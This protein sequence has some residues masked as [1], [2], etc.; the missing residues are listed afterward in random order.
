MQEQKLLELEKE[1]AEKKRR[2]EMYAAEREK[3]KYARAAAKQ[4][5]LL[6]DS[7]RQAAE[8]KRKQEEYAN[9]VRAQSRIGSQSS[10]AAPAYPAASVG[11]PSAALPPT[12]H[13]GHGTAYP[14]H[15]AVDH[16]SAKFGGM[17]MEER[18]A[19][20]KRKM[21]EDY[22]VDPR[23]PHALASAGYTDP[24]EESA[25]SKLIHANEAH[26][27]GMMFDSE[28]QAAEKR[29]KQ[30]EYAA[31]LRAQMSGGQTVD[32]KSKLIAANEQRGGGGGMQFDSERMA[33]EKRR[34]QSE[35][36]ADLKAQMSGGYGMDE[37][38]KLIAANEQRG[39]GGGMQFDSER[40]AAEK[41]RKQAEYAADLKAQMGGAYGMDEKSKLIAANEQRGGGGGMHFES[42]QMAAEKRRKQAEYAAD[43]K[44]QMG[45]AYGMDEKSKLI[46]ANEQRAGGGMQF[47]SER[48]AAE[49]RRKQAEYAADLK[50]QMSGAYG[51]D[52]KSKLIA[53]NEQRGGG[54][55]MQYDSE[56][57]AAEKRR[58]QA[59]YAADLRAQMGGGRADS[60]A[61]LQSNNE[62]AQGAGMQFDS[63]RMAAEKRRKQEEYAAD[64]RAQQQYHQQQA[65][66]HHAAH[67]SYAPPIIVPDSGMYGN[68]P[69][70]LYSRD[71]S[72]EPT[73]TG[74]QPSYPYQ[75]PS[76]GGPPTQ[77]YRDSLS[78]TSHAPTGGASYPSSAA[79]DADSPSTFRRRAND[80]TRSADEEKRRARD[81][82]AMLQEQLRLQIL[83]K[84]R[85]KAEEKRKIEEEERRAEERFRREQEREEREREEEKRKKQE[86]EVERLRREQEAAQAV[87]QARLPPRAPKRHG[88]AVEADD[89][90]RTDR[91]IERDRVTREKAERDRL[92]RERDGKFERDLVRQREVEP[93][94]RDREPSGAALPFDDGLFG[95]APNAPAPA[96]HHGPA[97]GPAFPSG[98]DPAMHTHFGPSHP[99]QPSPTNMYPV[100][101]PGV[102]Y[103]MNPL[104][105][106]GY[107]MAMPMPMPMQAQYPMHMPMAMPMQPM[108][109]PMMDPSSVMMLQQAMA[110]IETLR[111]E[112]EAERNELKS[113]KEQL[114][115]KLQERDHGVAGTSEGPGGDIY[116]PA[117]RPP[118]GTHAAHVGSGASVPHFPV[119]SERQR[120]APIVD[121][122]SHGHSL[123]PHVFQLPAKSPRRKFDDY[124]DMPGDDEIEPTLSPIPA[125]Q[126]ARSAQRAR[127]QALEASMLMQSMDSSSAFIFPP[128]G[129]AALRAD[130]PQHHGSHPLQSP[131]F[132]SQSNAMLK[133]HAQ[134]PVEK[135]S[136][137][138]SSRPVMVRHGR[139]SSSTNPSR[140]TSAVTALDRNEKRLQELEALEAQLTAQHSDRPSSQ[141]RNSEAG[142]M[143]GGAMTPRVAPAP[144]STSDAE[145]RPPSRV[146]TPLLPQSRPASGK[147]P[148]RPPS[149]TGAKPRS[150]PGSASAPSAN[151]PTE[152]LSVD[153]EG[154]RQWGKSTA[155]GAWWQA[156]PPDDD[157]VRIGTAQSEFGSMN[158]LNTSMAASSE[159]IQRPG[160][161]Q[162]HVSG[163]DDDTQLEDD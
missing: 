24:P 159:F 142:R 133:D 106:Q 41:R 70:A 91:E 146:A 76:K 28:R 74:S 25:K 50:A 102:G 45:G 44:A 80:E 112:M 151:Q 149:A 161:A 155:D 101:H 152:T 162:S 42:E 124:E 93:S 83:E 114:Q 69:P 158:G 134:R 66:H 37:K 148:A 92:D 23:R 14:S 34:K 38:S 143:D 100:H 81:Q 55:G 51:M 147:L 1:I 64:L 117:Y 77:P 68:V 47:D 113:E 85:Q 30:A 125:G 48:M 116:A 140:P 160:T 135:V 153:Q 49:K 26:S 110:Q 4:E 71:A 13:H 121:K 57:I 35:Y 120:D 82:K 20:E 119:G 84:E 130:T 107:P 99:A 104:P 98:P 60:K 72:Y 122:K 39:G 115:R 118:S 61:R 154:R 63:E 6:F 137:P 128:S 36:A 29:R 123:A 105:M 31:D 43:L 145:P 33:A 95:G 54:G 56:Q 136:S 129:N 94:V 15:P 16:S 127:P 22:G 12:A 65:A 88:Q 156:P 139:R 9:E 19:I 32:E 109:N 126:H 59:E 27:S 8:R 40:M 97:G 108:M 132:A 138:F 62:Q 86:A 96:F 53:V 144:V 73:P 58:K 5:G 111:R 78:P 90:P 141:P 131:G 67:D 163:F 157:S 52:E 18:I 21:Q 75:P 7:E 103:G 79:P 46:A 3:E 11:A 17:S 89:Q 150:R 10:H 2:D 87:A